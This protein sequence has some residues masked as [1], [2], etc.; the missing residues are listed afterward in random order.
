[1]IELNFLT[2]S[3]YLCMVDCVTKQ[4]NWVGRITILKLN[5]EVIKHHNDLLVR[6]LMKYEV[7]N[8]R[9]LSMVGELIYL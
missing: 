2:G 8:K 1:M 6:S 9:K 5:N 4:K 3:Q 7:I